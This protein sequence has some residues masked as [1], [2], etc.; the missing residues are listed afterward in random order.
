MK[1]LSFYKGWL[2]FWY[3]FVTVILYCPAWAHNPTPAAFGCYAQQQTTITGTIT[4]SGMPMTGV[5]IAVVGKQTAAVSGT[6][7]TFSINAETSDTLVFSFIGF[8]TVTVPLNGRA[9]VAVQLEEDTTALQEVT[10]NAGY[11]SVKEKERTGSIAKI[12][13]SDIERQPVTNPLAAMEGR[14]AGVSITQ[15]AGTPGSGFS[16]QI[17]GINAIRGEGN[18]PL[19]VIDGVPYASQSLGNNEVSNYLFGGLSSPMSNINPADIESI[20]VLKDADATAIY[21]SRGAN[22][23]VLITTKK[24]KAG[25]TKFD[26]QAYTTIGK[27][28]QNLN[29]LNTAEYLAIR[30]EAFANDGITDYPEDAYDVNGVW[31]QT[32]DTNWKKELIGGTANIYNAQ[33]SV[34]GGSARTQFLVSGTFRKE[35]T[36]FPGDAHYNR[37]AVHSSI[38]HRSEDEKFRLTF[39][40]DY[41]GDKNTLPGGDLTRQAYILAPNAPALYDNAGNLNWENGTFDNPLGILKS[42]YINKTNTLISNAMLSYTLPKGFEFRTSLG[43][44]DTSL[45][46]NRTLPSTMYTPFYEYTSAQSVLYT[47]DGTRRSWIIEP[48]LNW[49]KK[50]E[51]LEVNILAGTTFQS[52]KQNSLAMYGEGFPSNALINTLSAATTLSVLNDDFAEYKYN[53][54]FGR[55]NINLKDRYILNLTGRRDGSSRFGPA[56]RFANFGAVGTAWVFSKEPWLKSIENILS[57][58]KLRASYGITGNDQIGDY[59]FLDTYHVSL[60]VYDGTTGIQPTHLSNADFGWETNKKL[61]AAIELGFLKDRIFLTTAYFQNRSSNQLV[62]VPL[63]G[64]TGFPSIQSNLNATVRNTGLELEWR[65]VNFKNKDFNWTTTLNFTMPKNKLLSFPNLENSTY[66]N[67]YVVGESLSIQKVYHYT[68]INPATGLYTFEDFNGDGAVTSANDRQAV[69][70]LAPKYY[71]G[72]ANQFTYKNWSLDFLLQFVK[73]KGKNVMSTFPMPGTLSNQPVSVLTHYP[74]ASGAVQ[75]YSTGD[76]PGANAAYSNYTLSDA[77]VEDASFVRLK[78]MSLAYNIPAVWSK[79]L[80]AK[81]YMQGQN[82]LT[83]TKYRGADPENRATD[84]LPPLQQFTIGVQLSF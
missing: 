48:Q 25:K 78:S 19:Y 26:V 71:G 11:Y 42:I 60:N 31:D 54:F 63:P 9:S 77:M 70:D 34:S 29:L 43:F 27:V 83:F 13:A 59:Q 3:P 80:S 49:K 24:G 69:I 76:T 55:L 10:V 36:V 12:K 79:S 73:Q 57:F 41:S 18:D 14:M 37:G 22:G 17:R 23:V 56:N 82:L 53:A 28:T 16:I 51:S 7:G 47:N 50:W 38:T 46:E 8:K 66:K 58:G 1:K 72:L 15:A 45:S 68:G 64:T 61:E 44:S 75:Q 33:L 84:Y 39:S 67:L 6:D 32:R 5:S 35:T 40:A 20:E 4:V 81:V 62:G 30:R 21:G 52:Q 74:Q 2:P 65:S